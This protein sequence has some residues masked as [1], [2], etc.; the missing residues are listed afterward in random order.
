MK[1]VVLGTRGFPDVQGGVEKHAQELYGR[2]AS[3][4][5]DVTVIARAPY[6][7]TSAYQFQG[8]TILPLACPR[9]KFLEAI[10]HTFLGVLK[11]RS[12]NADIVHIHAIGPALTVPLAR[13]MGLKVVLTHHGFDYERKKWNSMA[14]AILKLG[15]TWGMAF[16]HRVIAVSNGIAEALYLKYA[17]RVAPIPNGV[18]MP[19]TGITNG[20]LGKLGL[21]KEKYIL[22]VGRLVPE[23]GFHELLESFTAL[24]GKEGGRWKLVIVGEADHDDEY[25]RALKTRANAAAN[26]VMAGRLKENAL[27]DLYSQAGL[28]VLPSHHEGLPI[29]L[30]EALS[31]GCPC[32]ASDI[33]PNR[34]LMLED[35]R[36]FKAGDPAAL[37]RKLSVLLQRPV[38]V[39]QRRHWIRNVREKYDWTTI[40]ERTLEIYESLLKD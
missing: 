30:L 4:G 19:E 18:T 15:E 25:S 8:V 11:A 13:L 37:T 26:V 14:K 5:C 10:V 23:K 20:T 3:L 6:V 34:E 7:G 35:E 38:S 27:K 33:G 1:I 39:D 17:R 28:F 36:Y 29:V 24:S 31:H 32:L 16:S 22:A 12:L 40:A 2:L 21:E 9:N